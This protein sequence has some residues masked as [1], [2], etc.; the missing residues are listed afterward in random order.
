[1]LFCLIYYTVTLV[2]VQY[3][4]LELEQL[5]LVQ[6]ITFGKYEK[7]HV[8]NLKRFQVYGGLTEDKLMLLLDRLVA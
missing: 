8:C 4:L 3:L 5:S 1:M 2:G 6:M 7:A